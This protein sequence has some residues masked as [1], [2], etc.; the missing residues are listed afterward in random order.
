MEDLFFLGVQS[1]KQIP[2]LPCSILNADKTQQAP[3]TASN[4][5][6]RRKRPF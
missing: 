3:G 4:R 5:Q 1:G 2:V 6:P